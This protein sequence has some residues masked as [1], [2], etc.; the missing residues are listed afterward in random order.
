MYVPI[1][2][3]QYFCSRKI[4]GAYLCSAVITFL[5]KDEFIKGVETG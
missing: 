2:I 3:Y 4:K 5:K 1:Q